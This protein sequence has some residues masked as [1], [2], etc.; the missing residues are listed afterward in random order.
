MAACIYYHP[1]AYTTSGPKLMGR[2]AAG[3]SFLRGFLKYTKASNFL[4]VQVESADHAEHFAS[5]A[6]HA[7]RT[8]QVRSFSKQNLGRLQEAGIIYFPGPALAEHAFHRRLYG[9]GRWSLS[10]ITHTTSSSIAMDAIADLLTAPIRPWDSLICT[11][12]AVKKNVEAILQAQAD[13]LRERLGISKLVLPLLPVIPLG[14]HTEDFAFT[15]Q[16]KRKARERL[17]VN[18]KELVV[19]YTGRLSFH[20]KAHPLAM[21]LGLEAAAKKSNKN[22]VLVEC[23]WHANQDIADSFAEAAKIACPSVRVVNVDGREQESRENAWGSADVFCSLSDN[24][25]ETFGIVPIEAMAA[26]LPVVVSD[27]DGYKD[28]VRDGVDGFRV[29]TMAPSQGLATDLAHRHALGVDNYDH[30]CGYSSSLV[31]VDV[32]GVERAFTKLF[33]SEELRKEMGSAGKKRAQN[34]YDWREIIRRYEELWNKQERIRLAEHKNNAR[35]VT[36]GVWPARLDP[37]V[38]F[39]NYPTKVLTVD[40]PLR[41]VPPD[42][43]AALSILRRYK[44]LVMVSFAALVM[45]TDEE[46]EHVLSAMSSKP[47]AASIILEGIEESRRPNVLRGLSWLAKLGIIDFS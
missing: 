23:G 45:P 41:L 25:Q 2:N 44:K 42:S 14:I 33:S 18:N 16:Q 27:W 40:T 22:V 47:Q 29:K 9:D 17:G 19:L 5:A 15:S 31:A 24:I 7:G 32:G 10:G 36:P 34:D 26:G 37:T 6:K 38:S 39:L 12:T 1:E 30:Y 28:T 20:A 46:L 13:Y 43:V 35:S 11:S 21:Y 4:S 3:E 8:E